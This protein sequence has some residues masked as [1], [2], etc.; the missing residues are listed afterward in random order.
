MTANETVSYYFS[1]AARILGLDDRL[2]RQLI[3][4]YRE[5]KVECSIARDDGSVA[6]YVGF[7]VQH[8]NSRGP[9]KGGIRY[10]PE[11]D[12]DE[13]NA[14]ASLMTWKTAVVNLP[15]GGAKGGIAVD[16]S[17]LSRGE[18]QRL[19]RVYVEKLHDL[20]GPY[21]DIPAP[22][23]GTDAEV[24]GWIVD[25]Y[26]KFHGWAPGVVTGK[27]V[28]LGGS[29]G[30][31]AATGRGLLYAAQCFFAD[32]G[33]HISDFRYA[34]QGFG[35]VGSWAARLFHEAGGRIVAVSDVHSALYNPQG[36]D[37]PAL[38][39]YTK[40]HH[41]RLAGFPGAEQHPREFVLSAPCDVFI[42]AA[43]G[44]VLTRQTA[45]AVQARYV[46]E[47][48]N[49]PSDPE[50]DAIFAQRGITVL[51]DI[52]ANAGGVTV[53]YFEWVQNIQQYRWDEARVNEELSRVM[54]TAYADLLATAARYGCSLRIAAYVLAVSRVERATRL[55][56]L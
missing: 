39:N 54:R 42:P 31:E 33:Q 52:Y 30:R 47:G 27:P 24:M 13:V 29:L 7:R 35:N 25:E 11:V 9:M 40:T 38:M 15:Y 49:H 55:R 34:I 45:P 53:S 48:A 1:E 19:T 16:P 22:D 23:M 4:P 43:L 32:H 20:I 8:D 37:I 3:T 21:V 41:G 26:S 14:L 12:P 17:K 18:L 10:H 28:E 44:G 6:T 46:L 36:I 51:P 56:G 2:W 50:A 5:V